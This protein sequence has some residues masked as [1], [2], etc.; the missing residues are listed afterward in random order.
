MSKKVKLLGTYLLGRYKIE[1]DEL[2]FEEEICA[3]SK[4]LR[5]NEINHIIVKDNDMGV[6]IM[7]KDDAP[8]ILVYDKIKKEWD[9]FSQYL[10]NDDD[11]PKIYAQY[12]IPNNLDI[13]KFIDV[14]L[15]TSKGD[16]V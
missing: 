3:L 4:K 12:I 14:I 5:Q 16:N 7:L 13:M 11:D 9:Y 2:Q 1:K 6:G 8:S 10:E 15:K